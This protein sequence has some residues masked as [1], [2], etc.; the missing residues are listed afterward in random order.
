[1]KTKQFYERCQLDDE[2][3]RLAGF[4]P[5]YPLLGSGLDD[6]V[7]IAN[8]AFID[9]ASNNYLG[10]ANDLRVKEAAINGIEKYGVSLCA[11]PV[12]SGY[13]ELFKN[14]EEAL[15]DFVD[16]EETIILPSCYQ[17][18]N[19]LFQVIALPDDLILVDRDAHSSLM[20][21]IRS[22]SCTFRLFRHNDMDH[23]QDLLNRN[24]CTG[25][26]FVVTESV[27]STEG[28]IAPMDEINTL[29][30]K[31]GAIPVVD[32]SHG[33]GVIGKNGEGVLSHF[34]IKDYQGIYT[35]SLGKAM[36][37]TGGMISGKAS[38][39]EY[40]R[41][42][43][44]HLIYSTA[45]P[46]APLMAVLEVL[47]IIDNEFS[48]LSEKMWRYAAQ[49]KKGFT[50]AGF[51]MVSSEA[52]INSIKSGNSV[53]TLIL[54]RKFHELGILTTPFIYPSVPEKE[55]R[56]RLIAGANLS[57][58]SIEYV[59]QSITNIQNILV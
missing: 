34:S 58:V 22:A 13:S 28:A 39:I 57:D 59:L 6:P 5:Y 33:I 47:S 23:L 51:S 40:L 1:M 16:L 24:K 4:N 25:Q 53:E 15:S 32:D 17:A 14:V 18:N 12:A 11:T 55:G 38:L 2:V 45:L 36:S 19:G 21:G 10:L 7:V 48:S 26:V 29:C 20:E 42:S 37:T 43:I 49:L 46:P 52:P 27:F 56:I 8:H 41:Y 35:A 9:L 31:Y 54:T 50:N 3:A 44:S 30:N